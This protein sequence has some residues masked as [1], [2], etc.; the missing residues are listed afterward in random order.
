MLVFYFGSVNLFKKMQFIHTN[1]NPTS[2]MSF[3]SEI[4]NIL[5]LNFFG[6]NKIKKD[7]RIY[8]H[9]RSIIT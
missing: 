4:E 9:R 5:V 3:N 7:I 1:E 2:E 8:S 6:G